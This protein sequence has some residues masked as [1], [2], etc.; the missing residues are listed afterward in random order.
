[1]WGSDCHLKTPEDIDDCFKRL[2]S[3]PQKREVM[4]ENIAIRV[5]G[6]N[7]KDFHHNKSKNGTKFT[8]EEL[9]KHLKEK[10]P[11][12]QA[13][14]KRG[15]IPL[16]RPPLNAPRRK[17]LPIL[18][19]I[20][21]QLKNLDAKAA[22]ENEKVRKAVTILTKERATRKGKDSIYNKYQP[23]FKPFVFESFVGQQIDVKVPINN[24]EG[25]AELQ[26]CQGEVSS[27]VCVEDADDDKVVPKVMVEWDPTP[28]L[29]GYEE[30]TKNVVEL[31]KK[32]WKR[33]AKNGW[34]MDVDLDLLSEMVE[35]QQA[36]EEVVM[37]EA[38]GVDDSANLDTVDD[39]WEEDEFG[40]EEV[41]DG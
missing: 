21:S 26:W 22:K 36:D 3:E 31:K 7:L 23:F 19:S 29:E 16:S 24:D 10:L 14:I 33:N 12:E 9:A 38:A 30:T 20:T 27:I 6:Q 40:M 1:M 11:E 39:A 18:G 37:D 34:R 17:Y 35:E 4:Y 5:K 13:M 8:S 2:K 25:K 32:N 15:E 41:D 28:D